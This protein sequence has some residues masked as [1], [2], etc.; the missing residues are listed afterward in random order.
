[1]ERQFNA[2]ALYGKPGELAAHVAFTAE[3]ADRAAGAARQ[4]RGG[5]A[6][7]RAAGVLPGR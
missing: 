4:R 5:R 7:R 3:V 6:G 1:V 2:G